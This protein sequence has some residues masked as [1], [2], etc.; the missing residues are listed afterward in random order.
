[1]SVYADVNGQTVKKLRLHIGA[2]GPWFADCT[3]DNEAA[4]V[5]GAVLLSVGGL[6]LNGTVIAEQSGTYTS[7]RVVRIVAG[8]G[9]W[10]KLLSAKAYHSDSG[11]RAYIPAADAARE[12][13]EVLG[14]FAPEQDRIGIDYVRQAGPASRA[15]EDLIG[16]VSWWVDYQGVTQAGARP[17]V[18]LSEQSYDVTSYDP[19]SNLVTLAADDLTVVTVGSVL[20]KTLDGPHTV[21]DLDIE[22][23]AEQLV[24][25][26]WCSTNTTRPRL[27][28]L[29]EVLVRRAMDGKLF[30]LYEY[31]LVAMIGD[32]VSLQAVRNA[33]GLPDLSPISMCPGVAGAHAQLTPGASV[34]VQFVEGERTRPIVT[35]FAGKDGTGFVPVLLTFGDATTADFVALAGKVD[36]GLGKLQ[37]A[38]D[39]HV[40]AT[41]GTGTPSGPTIVPGVIPVGTLD[42]TAASKVKAS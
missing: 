33:A 29:L 8:G 2:A 36:D 10:S 17:S 5:A 18:Q 27:V 42:S 12:A 24:I 39:Q 1:M 16:A 11:I 37:S 35:G 31:R 6:R 34:Y 19:S 41:A 4:D 32:R 13:G 21:R 26:A 3:F 22:V 28:Q 25:K 15:L 30:G 7:A 40:H 38:F 20:T 14:S 23:D 9:G